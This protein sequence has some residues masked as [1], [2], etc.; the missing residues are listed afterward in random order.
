MR[1]LSKKTTVI[2]RL[3]AEL[4]AGKGGAR[5]SLSTSESPIG[6][7]WPEVENTLAEKEAEVAKLNIELEERSRTT[8]AQRIEI[9]TLQIEID[10]LR[11]QIADLENL[12]LQEWNGRS[13]RRAALRLAG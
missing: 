1:D 8:D 10:A 12:R 13:R 7:N 4:N 2:N 3:Q 11:R 9:V 5:P 6:N